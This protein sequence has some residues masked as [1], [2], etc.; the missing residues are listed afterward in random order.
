MQK[1]YRMIA[2]CIAL[3]LT[4]GLL[5]IF[6]PMT[7]EASA[8][9][10]FTPR[11]E[12]PDAN[13]R[14]FSTDNP[15]HNVGNRMP[16]CTTYAWGRAYEILGSRPNLNIG[17]ARYWFTNTGPF[18]N[19]NDRYER[20]RVPRLGAIA[21]WGTR[22]GSGF[23]HVSVVEYVFPDGSFKTSGSVWGGAFFYTTI[24]H[25]LP[26]DFQGFIYLGNFVMAQEEAPQAELP[27]TERPPE[28]EENVSLTV[29][30][31]R[32]SE[33]NDAP[34]TIGNLISLRGLQEVLGGIT[35]SEISLHSGRT[36]NTFYLPHAGGGTVTIF[37][38]QGTATVLMGDFIIEPELFGMVRVDG[39][40]YLTMGALPSLLGYFAWVQEEYLH[41]YLLD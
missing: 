18:P 19:A 6:A 33:I 10:P 27:P 2:L 32:T 7:A 23:G 39:S 38:Y 41:L 13:D 34:F 36:I 40:W 12:A 4:L 8:P 9:L 25:T 31:N 21:V 26:S 28:I 15:F 37:I 30:I 16:N 3:V 14:R 20:G 35:T 11:L 1:M 24:T 22:V 29:P 5:G 17:H